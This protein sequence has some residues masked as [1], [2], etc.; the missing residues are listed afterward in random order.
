MIFTDIELKCG[1]VGAEV[2]LQHILQALTAVARFLDD[3]DALF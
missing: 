3:S 1:V 2:H